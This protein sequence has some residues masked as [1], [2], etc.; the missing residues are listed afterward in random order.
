MQHTE[1]IPGIA[2]AFNVSMH[3]H[4]VCLW[5]SVCKLNPMLV[6]IPFQISL[7]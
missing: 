3:A 1:A 6:F 7:K 5:G 4:E 2:M